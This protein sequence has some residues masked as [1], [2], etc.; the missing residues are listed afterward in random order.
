MTKRRVFFH[1]LGGS[2]HYNR[3]HNSLYVRPPYGNTE[4]LFQ[5]ECPTCE[6][7]SCVASCD[8]K[9]IF[10]A[11]DNTPRLTFKQ[12]GCTFCDACAQACELGVLSLENKETAMQ[13]N[14]IFRISLNTCV[15]HHGVI[16][17][18][19]KEPCIDD[20][21]LFNGLFNPIIDNEK[22][23]ACGFCLS[24]CPTQA[25]TYEPFVLEKNKENITMA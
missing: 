23:T 2:S 4:S 20:A 18:T 1:T 3:E 14:A 6:S 9:I 10:I 24:R 19:C 13:L 7:N 17:H 25:I 22:C 8:E 11:D 21:I 16:C 5:K 15:A 12:N